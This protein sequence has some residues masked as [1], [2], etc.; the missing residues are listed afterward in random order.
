MPDFFTF[1]NDVLWGSV[2]IYLLF[3]AGCWFTWRTG[4]VQFRY[5]RQVGKSL[6][7]SISPQPGGL[8]SFQSLCTSLAARIGSGNMAGVALAITAGGPGAVFWMW[9]AAIIGMATSFAECAL[10]QLYK[11]RDRHGQ[12]RGGPAWYMARGLGMRWMG[13]LFAIFLLI[14]YG[15]VFNS[16]QANSVSRALKFAFDFPPIATGIVMAI[17]ALLVIVRGIKGVAQMMQWFV[18]VMALM[19]VVTSLVICLINI[20]QL[21]DILI[22]I[23]KSAFGWQEAAGGVAGYTLSQAITS[24]FQ[25]SMFSN[26]A[27]MG[28]TPNAA[29][30][31]ASWPPHPAAQ[32]IVQMIG[33]FIDTLVVCSATAMLVLLAGN[34]TTY[35]P[36]EGIQLVQKAMTVLVGDWGAAFVAVIVILFAFSSIVV[37]YI[38]AEN[39]LYFLNLDNKRTIWILRIATCSTVVV[40]T[41]L[42][43][44]LLWQLADIIM[45][46]M[47]ITNLTAILLLSPVVHTLASDYLRQRKLGIRPVFDPLRYPDIEQQLAPDAWDDIPRD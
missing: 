17:A 26:E 18:P 3:G 28:S 37:N 32:G 44:P 41:L 19:W 7:N 23:I 12:F 29:A 34:G 43:F 22:S 40:G 35:A 5:I 8:T 2:M 13:V 47:A 42:S 11:E 33:I 20:D 21:P 14:A 10:A 16:V 36:M 4:F 6:K 27:G 1:I 31:A 46:C 15:L 39:N 25:R 9:V 24:G 30:A 38:Y 45:A